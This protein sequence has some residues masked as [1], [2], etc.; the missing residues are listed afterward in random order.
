MLTV[1]CWVLLS[2]GVGRQS[3]AVFRAGRLCR[4]HAQP[5][6]VPD[7]PKLP[8]PLPEDDSR[9][10]MDARFGLPLRR[11]FRTISAA[12]AFRGGLAGAP[13]R[14]GNLPPL[15]TAPAPQPAA[16]GRQGT[17]MAWAQDEGKPSGGSPLPEAMVAEEQAALMSAA[18]ESEP[19]SKEATAALRAPVPAGAEAAETEEERGKVHELQIQPPA[20]PPPATRPRSAKTDVAASKKKTRGALLGGLRSGKLEAAVTKMEND[21]AEEEGEGAKEEGAGQTGLEGTTGAGTAGTEPKSKRLV[22]SKATALG[23]QKLDEHSENDPILKVMCRWGHVQSS[24]DWNNS[25][26]D[27]P[28]ELSIDVPALAPLPITVSV[29][30]IDDDLQTTDDHIGKCSI[31]VEELGSKALGGL[32]LEPQGTLDITCALV[33]VDEH[34]DA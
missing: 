27:W 28:E 4:R 1:S 12:A 23:L 22:F 24:T 10:R 19:A 5:G 9:S 32:A 26:P 20:E 25:S 8:P 29:L 3:T 14:G 21:L 7:P 11:S 15:A 17:A 31:V 33:E 2:R 6:R 16:M 18:V 34:T 13:A 30:I